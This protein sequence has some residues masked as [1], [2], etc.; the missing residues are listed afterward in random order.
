[1][2]RFTF[3]FILL[4]VYFVTCLWKGV[5]DVE[6][7][8]WVSLCL[9]CCVRTMTPATTPSVRTP[10]DDT[11]GGVSSIYPHSGL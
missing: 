10:R 7:R 2:C 4:L 9:L 6:V 5:S 1:M 8:S 3:A 11:M